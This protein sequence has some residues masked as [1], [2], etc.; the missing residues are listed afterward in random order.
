MPRGVYERKQ[1]DAGETPQNRGDCAAPQNGWGA[2]NT[3]QAKESAADDWAVLDLSALQPNLPN[4]GWH[5]AKITQAT[6][7]SGADALWL[8]IT[9]QLPDGYMPPAMMQPLAAKPDSNHVRRVPDGLRLMFATAKA[10]G[11]ELPPQL[12]P[13]ALEELFEG[14]TIDVKLAQKQR[15]G[16]NEMVIRKT[17][18]AGTGGK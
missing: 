3:A 11:V 8:A 9:C 12:T 2:I 14:K 15:D 18:P 17:A 16:V 1:K 4:A 6:V 13:D 5:T 7:T 10:V